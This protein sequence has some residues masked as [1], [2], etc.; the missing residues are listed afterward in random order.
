MQISVCNQNNWLDVLNWSVRLVG[1][2]DAVSA[3]EMEKN[4]KVGIG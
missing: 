3:V 2:N 1:K 4:W